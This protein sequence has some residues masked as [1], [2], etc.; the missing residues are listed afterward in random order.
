VEAEHRTWSHQWTKLWPKGDVALHKCVRHLDSIPDEVENDSFEET[1]VNN[2]V[3]GHFVADDAFKL[4]T[5]MSALL[6]SGSK[7]YY[8][9]NPLT[10]TAQTALQST[11]IFQYGV[12]TGQKLKA[13][14]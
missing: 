3:F 7:Q 8:W 1:G 14:C 4:H 12:R 9:Q 11:G 6:I 5:E 2:N 13:T 10:T